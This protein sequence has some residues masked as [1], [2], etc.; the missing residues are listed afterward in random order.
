LSLAEA[1]KAFNEAIPLLNQISSTKREPFG[2]PH[3]TTNP[4]VGK[5]YVRN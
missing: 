5:I 2:I 1:A 4:M 3:A